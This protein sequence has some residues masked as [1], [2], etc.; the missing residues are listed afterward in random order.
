VLLYT[1]HM[2]CYDFGL[3][4]SSLHYNG[5]NFQLGFPL[6][7]ACLLPVDLRAVPPPSAHT[8]FAHF[9]SWVGV[10]ELQT[11]SCCLQVPVLIFMVQASWTGI[12]RQQV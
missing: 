10:R 1:H 11:S 5:A 6:R 3:L 12:Q 4:A 7:V 9:Y 8:P 2:F